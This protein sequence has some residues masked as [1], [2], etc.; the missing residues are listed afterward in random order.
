MAPGWAAPASNGRAA[1]T[2]PIQGSGRCGRRLRKWWTVSQSW[3]SGVTAS[4]P[5]STIPSVHAPSIFTRAT[6]TRYIAFTERAKP[7]PSDTRCLRDASGCCTMTSST[8]PTTS[9]TALQSSSCKTKR[10]RPAA[11]RSFF[12]TYPDRCLG[13]DRDNAEFHAAVLRTAELGGVVGNRIGLATP[14][15]KEAAGID[16]ELGQR[17]RHRGSTLLREGQVVA[18]RT[19]RVGVADDIDK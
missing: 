19:R 7:G 8:W 13:A 10:A 4:L 11:A 5:A 17:T 9:A 15:D 6:A 16:A 3:K 14:F 1:G 18:V 2:L 12:S